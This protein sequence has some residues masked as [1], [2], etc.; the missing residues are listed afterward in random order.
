MDWEIFCDHSYY[1]LWA[2]RP[3]GEKR[4]GKCFHVQSH[5]EADTL[6]DLLI[7]LSKRANITFEELVALI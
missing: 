3:V 2:V 4:W 1:D 6:R 5:G 7:I